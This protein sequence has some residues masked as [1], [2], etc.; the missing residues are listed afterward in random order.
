MSNYYCKHPGCECVLNDGR[1]YCDKHSSGTTGPAGGPGLKGPEGG[2]IKHDDGKLRM[3]LIPPEAINAL[4][5]VLTYGVDQYGE[6]N[7]ERGIQYSRIYAAVQRHL[8]A[9]WGGGDI[10]E[11]SGIHHLHHALCGLAFLITYEG[12]GMTDFDDR[13]RK[14]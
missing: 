3:D 1:L 13:P 2:G 4:A 9:W 6:R 10:D 8:W 11:E 14:E 5:E 12:R 7:W